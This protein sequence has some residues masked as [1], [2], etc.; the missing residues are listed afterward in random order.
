MARRAYLVASVWLSL[1]TADLWTR[2]GLRTAP[3]VAKGRSDLTGV[4]GERA[5]G[6]VVQAARQVLGADSGGERRHGDEHGGA[7]HGGCW[8]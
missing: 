7:E 2:G 6:R 8:W 4:N 1:T 5:G 3:C